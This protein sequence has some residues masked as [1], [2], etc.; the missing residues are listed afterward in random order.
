M[1]MICVPV[2]KA[3]AVA[4]LDVKRQDSLEAVHVTQFIE[5]FQTDWVR[6]SHE[7]ASVAICRQTFSL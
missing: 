6:F 1:L 5:C 7:K 2:H 4:V 3:L